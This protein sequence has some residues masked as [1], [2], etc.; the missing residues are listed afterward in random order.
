[1]AVKR[2]LDQGVT[3]VQLAD[4]HFAAFVRYHKSF[5]V[6]RRLKVEKRDWP[7][8]VFVFW[9]KGSGTGK[10]RTSMLLMSMLG[11]NQKDFFVVPHGKQSGLYWDGYDGQTSVLLDEFSG[12]FCTPT[13]LNGLLDRY[14]FSVPVHG[15]GNVE[16][17][18]KYVFITSNFDPAVWWKEEVKWS[19]PALLRRLSVVRVFDHPKALPNLRLISGR[20]CAVSSQLEGL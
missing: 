15:S 6:Y 7:M 9:S 17:T 18:S 19:Y 10:T 4:N 14:P 13:F 3:R 20:L 11:Q 16:F 12:S 1:M 5:D 8:T 2:D